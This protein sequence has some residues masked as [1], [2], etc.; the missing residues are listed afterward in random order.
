MLIDSKEAAARLGLS[1]IRVIKL[2]GEGRIVGGQ[3]VG[4]QRG[5][6]VIEVKGDEAPEIL[7]SLKKPRKR[8]VIARASVSASA[9]A[10]SPVPGS[11]PAPALPAAPALP[12]C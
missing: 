8:N 3:K 7:P 6:W 4:G 1:T 11:L 2:L 10:S 12:V 9:S 5:L